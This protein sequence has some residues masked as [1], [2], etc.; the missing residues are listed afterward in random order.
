MSTLFS[1]KLSNIVNN[2]FDVGFVFMVF[3]FRKIGGC[4][5]Y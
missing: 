5:V 3:C 4:R 2:L 1:I